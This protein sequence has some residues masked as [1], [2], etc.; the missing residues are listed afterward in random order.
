MLTIFQQ[1]WYFFYRNYLFFAPVILI[2]SWVSY[3][4]QS[5]L[6]WDQGTLTMEMLVA[7]YQSFAP[8][9]EMI[10]SI[11]LFAFILSIA[12]RR[13]R[14]PQE[15]VIACITRSGTSPDLWR[16]IGAVIMLMAVMLGVVM[17]SALLYMLFSHAIVLLVVIIVGIYIAMRL[18]YV[19]YAAIEDGLVFKQGIVQSLKLSRGP[20][21]WRLLGIFAAFFALYVVVVSILSVI[22]TASL[23]GAGNETAQLALQVF[24]GGHVT[25]YMYV[26]LYR[27]YLVQKLQDA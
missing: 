17:S 6:D 2:S 5:Q 13:I 12:K 18:V 19:P 22:P 8:L 25:V 9:K 20:E 7:Y 21:G 27:L 16:V 24:A 11:V 26:T 3:T 15:P 1:S 14:E 23:F 4:T 10:V